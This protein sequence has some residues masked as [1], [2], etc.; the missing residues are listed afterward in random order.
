MFL[1]Y[2][3]ET[4]G[5]PQFTR[6]RGYYDPHNLAKYDTCR[7]VSISWILLDAQTL[8]IVDKQTHIIKPDGYVISQGSINIHGITNE[9]AHATGVAMSKILT[10]ISEFAPRVTT[11]VAHNVMFDVNALKS[12]AHR[13]GYHGIAHD[14]DRAEKFCTMAKAKQLLTLPKNPKLSELYQ[15]LYDEEMTNA[16]DAEFDT[17][18][19]YKC[20][21]QLI[22]IPKRDTSP[23]SSRAP[24][25]R[26]APSTSSNTEPNKTPRFMINDQEIQLNP[27]QAEVIFAD[28]NKNMLILASAGSGK[29]TTIVCRI[30]HL[31]DSGVPE[32]SIV[33]T[34]F[35]RDA[36]NDMQAK[37]E[38]VLGY[39]HQIE[40]GTIDSLALKYVKR[41]RPEVL[42]DSSV[43]VGEYAIQFLDFLKTTTAKENFLKEITHLFVDE[44]QDINEVQYKIIREFYK[45]GSILT[46]VGDDA[47]NIYSFRGSD[48]KYILNFTDYFPKASTFTLTTNYRSTH[49]IVTFA[50]AS[51]EKNEFQL[52]KV[53][54]SKIQTP[55]G[56]RPKV[57]FFDSTQDQYR[58]IRK[59]IEEYIACGYK[60]CQMAVLCPQNSFLYQLEE[61]LT[62]HNV[63]NVLLDGKSDVRTRVKQDHVCLSTIHKSKGLEWDIV[64]M[65]MMNDE[66]FP[67]RKF[68]KDVYESRRLFYVGITRPKTFLHITCAPINGCSFISRFVSEV[69]PVNYE[70]LNFRPA[71]HL[72]TSS[73]SIGTFRRD[74]PNLVSRV[75]GSNYVE[76]KKLGTFPDC[77]Q[78]VVTL[79][80]P[81]SYSSVIIDNDICGDFALF[82]GTML[83]RMIAEKWPD[84]GGNTCDA[85]TMARNCVKLDFAEMQVYKKYRNNFQLNLRHVVPYLD[86]I[87]RNMRRVMQA[88]LKGSSRGIVPIDG[89]DMGTILSIIHKL[90][91]K[92]S[93]QTLLD[94]IPIFSERFL[95]SDFET[96][97]SDAL[98]AFQNLENKWQDIIPQTW[99]IS[100]CHQI[101]K[102]R[103]RRLLYKHVTPKDLESHID[104]YRDMANHIVPHIQNAKHGRGLQNVACNM[105]VRDGDVHGTIDVVAGDVLYKYVCSTEDKI[106]ADY[107]LEMLVL[108]QLYESESD[109]LITHI[110]FIN[111]LRGRV[112]TLDVAEFDKGQ[113]L[114][115]QLRVL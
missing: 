6:F 95:P 83:S 107:I 4:S 89:D 46:C 86:D 113:D 78:Q 50:N 34:T 115:S 30:K 88:L 57:Q 101:V 112:T 3:T 45:N 60:L 25:R 71:E 90:K 37:L 33:L 12:E 1:V 109:A 2:D 41:Y 70:L 79:Y 91:L 99:H 47:Q 55:T 56:I 72:G 40:V 17:Y 18:Y 42:S 32:S 20:F 11:I 10:I 76:M 77:P 48:I 49:D 75:D 28:P 58:F 64:F 96:V 73:T 100:K 5:L 51:I 63:P 68:E 81:H 106:K 43:N 67:A 16:H 65:M 111:M 104:L 23:S 84:S 61:V 15:L 54:V 110:S 74:V 39:K 14:L 9:R 66:I 94:K 8:E 22:H 29:T 98:D 69:H 114:L 19:C 7:I 108:K 36:A 82:L 97:M 102:E 59:K 92:T 85:A 80:A 35:T 62:K 44:F 38:S 87:H 93:A 103:R 53:M 27:E 26:D 24:K 105:P 13:Y 52:P 21:M 31:I